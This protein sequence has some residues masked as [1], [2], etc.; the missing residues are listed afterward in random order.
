MKHSK[1]SGNANTDVT[2]VGGADWDSAH[3]HSDGD[4][5]LLGV[6]R[7]VWAGTSISGGWYFKHVVSIDYDAVGSV[8]IGLNFST[9][10]KDENTGGTAHLQIIAVPTAGGL[11]GLPTGCKFDVAP[12]SDIDLSSVNYADLYL[13]LKDSSDAAVNPT[14]D[15]CFSV[16]FYGKL[17]Y[18]GIP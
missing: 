5:F 3:V 4:V 15:P 7:F 2:K 14:A 8:L 10:L 18:T 11:R 6:A 12:V 13:T 17:T 1:K 16:T 9:F